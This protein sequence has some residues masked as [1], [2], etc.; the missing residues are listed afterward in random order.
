MSSFSSSYPLFLFSPSRCWSTPALQVQISC[1]LLHVNRA[2]YKPFDWLNFHSSTK[3]KN[4]FL[5]MMNDCRGDKPST[6]MGFIS[7]GGFFSPFFSFSLTLSFTILTLIKGFMG[8]DWHVKKEPLQSC[9]DYYKQKKSRDL[10]PFLITIIQHKMYY[11][12]LTSS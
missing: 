11:T 3:G 6:Y 7:M 4:A 8:S 5:L 9:D 10:A 1:C 2:R 12:T